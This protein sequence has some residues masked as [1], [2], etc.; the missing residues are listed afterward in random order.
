V[1][2][3]TNE[4]IQPEFSRK[5]RF[6]T[7]GF[8]K[9]AKAE[10]LSDVALVG[11]ISEVRDGLIDAR[12]GGNLVKKRIAIGGTGKRGGLRSIL[13]YTGPTGNVFC[14]YVFAKRETD[15][16]SANQLKELKLLAKVLLGW[17]DKE[18]DKAIKTGVLEG[19][20]GS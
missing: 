20:R 3:L 7:R 8:A 6:K 16:I 10:G 12:L 13:V 18:I 1:V 4:N 15:N 5:V 9:G 14:V 2:Y 17:K 11:G 19:S